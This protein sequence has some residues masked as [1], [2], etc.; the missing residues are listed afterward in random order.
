MVYS[1]LFRCSGCSVTFSDPSA[2]REAPAP[3]EVMAPTV[4]SLTTVVT[5]S[6]PPARVPNLSTWGVGGTVHPAGGTVVHGQGD[7]DIKQIHD[8]A[9]RANRSKSKGRRR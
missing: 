3:E 2:W 9:A 1:G 6:A 5:R 7:D 4:D 8:A